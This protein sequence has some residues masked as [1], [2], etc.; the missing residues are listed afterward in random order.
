[1]NNE[2]RIIQFVERE[3]SPEEERAVLDECAGSDEMRG[4]LKQH[5]SLSRN[6][7]AALAS[8]TV[9]AAAEQHLSQRIA[10]MRPAQPAG[11]ASRGMRIGGITAVIAGVATVAFMAMMYFGPQSQTH[12]PVTQA[13]TPVAAPAPQQTSTPALAEAPVVQHKNVSIHRHGMRH[14]DALPSATA[15]ATSSP[16]ASRDSAA[17][18]RKPVKNLIPLTEK[19]E[20]RP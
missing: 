10:T 20:V 1:M 3:L 14:A 15:D 11:M 9:P 8:V 2:D 6:V 5:V 12:V 16:L 13:P 4:L 17:P 7:A 18:Q 19:D